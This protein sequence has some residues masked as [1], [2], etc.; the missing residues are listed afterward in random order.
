[1]VSTKKLSVTTTMKIIPRPVV[2]EIEDENG[3][4]ALIPV[5]L[6]AHTV[7]SSAML[8]RFDL[9]PIL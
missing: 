3:R 6:D 9:R 1:M 8:R 4:V 5:E 2:P 7:K